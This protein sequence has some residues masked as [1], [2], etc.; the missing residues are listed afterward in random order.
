MAECIHEWGEWKKE[1][2]YVAGG[3]YTAEFRKC[4][5]CDAVEAKNIV[6]DERPA[7][8]RPTIGVF[9]VIF[10]EEGKLLLRRRPTGS[11]FAGEWD[12]PGGGVDAD[13][14]SKSL[15][16]RIV[17]QELAR[18]AREETGISIPPMLPMVAMYPAVLKSGGD[19]A[20]AIH[21]GVVKEKPTKSET[22]YVSPQELREL[23]D[24]PEGNRLLSGWG[25]RMCRLC[26]RLLASRDAPNREFAKQAGG[27]LTEIMDGWSK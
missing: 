2:W 22:R 16:E 6:K 25:K 20:F 3:R 5:K 11:S 12:L 27:M 10:N 9:A 18:E 13:N 23:A 14:A 4:K 24:G 26:L 7:V 1:L 17:V 21:V 15:D 19:W 8:V